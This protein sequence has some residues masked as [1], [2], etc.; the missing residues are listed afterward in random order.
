MTDADKPAFGA[1]LT[2]ALAYWRQDVSEFTLRVWWDGCRSFDLEQVGRAL[3]AHA[4]DPER[5]RFPPML[6]DVVKHLLG[7]QADRSLIAWGK[8]YA[9]AHAVGA[10]SSVAFD[11]AAIHAAIEDMGGW[12]QFC[13]S[14]EHE[15]PHL[16]RRFCELHRAHSA[17]PGVYPPRLIGRHEQDNHSTGRA[18]PDG[19]LTALVG[20]LAR[21]R[22]VIAQGRDGGRLQ[23]R[24]AGVRAGD[25]VP[26]RMRGA[27]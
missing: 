22:E 7:T 13:S 18:P 4:A 12:V 1:L 26:L 14:T 8:V 20:D 10:Y 11:D 3:S 6:A 21:C 16:Q 25:V 23:V 9:A 24:L 5:G 15:L 19:E 27:A 17:R 2:D